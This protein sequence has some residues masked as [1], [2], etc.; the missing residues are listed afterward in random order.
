MTT[1]EFWIS[2]LVF[3]A[4][5]AVALVVVGLLTACVSP[6]A[7]LWPP[8]AGEKA[9]R[10][11]VYGDG[12]HSL[13]EFPVPGGLEEW[14]YGERIWF[15]DD[16]HG[17]AAEKMRETWYRIISGLRAL[18]W[19]N[20]GV[21][22]ITRVRKPYPA[23]NPDDTVRAWDFAISPAG[24]RRMRAY[25]ENTRASIKPILDDG[26][27]TYYLSKQRYDVLHTCHHYTARALWEAG[28]PVHGSQCLIPAGFWRQ[29]NRLAA[30]SS[31][32]FAPQ[33]QKTVAQKA[34]AQKAVAQKAAAG[35]AQ[36]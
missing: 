21:I 20:A 23:Q 16:Q 36:P 27:Q 17:P 12:F 34:V 11:T 33:R 14:A 35:R 9:V 25:L 29:L 8:H 6:P 31:H 1:N 30:G 24:L 2:R 10:L 15:C 32:Q 28:V 26:G 3:P 18:F 19:P 5:V 22:E 13:I 4:R 7:G